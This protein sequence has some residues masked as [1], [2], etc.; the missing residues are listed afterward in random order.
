MKKITKFKRQ[1]FEAVEYLSN[2]PIANFNRFTKK[3]IKTAIG[4]ENLESKQDLISLLTFVFDKTLT[5]K[6]NFDH[7]LVNLKI[8]RERKEKYHWLFNNSEWI[9]VNEV[10]LDISQHI[11]HG[12]T[13]YIEKT[14]TL[15]KS[16]S[17][18]NSNT[19]IEFKSDGDSDLNF[20]ETIKF[21]RSKRSPK[22]DSLLN[23]RCNI[24]LEL[25]GIIEMNNRLCLIFEDEYRMQNSLIKNPGYRLLNDEI[26]FMLTHND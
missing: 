26:D 18:L 17:E 20:N 4:K 22:F 14:I 15:I 9:K 16:E 24:M 19:V 2:L 12:D 21:K 10:W 13:E 7:H 5:V 23:F 25:G 11:R 3:E 6:L 1:K 8:W